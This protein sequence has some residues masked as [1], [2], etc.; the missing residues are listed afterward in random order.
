MQS[1]HCPVLI[2]PKLVTG[3]LGRPILDDIEVISRF[4]SEF[5]YECFG[6]K[7]LSKNK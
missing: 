4:L 5:I 6:K 2:G 7:R 1:F 3:H